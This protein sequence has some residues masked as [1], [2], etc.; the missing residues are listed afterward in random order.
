[1]T[2]DEQIFRQK[3]IAAAVGIAAGALSAIV[4]IVVLVR[5][6]QRILLI[7][8]VTG[9]MT[10]FYLARRYRTLTEQIELEQNES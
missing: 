1:M 4:G 2:Q 7:S 5:D 9:A 6:G 10:A 8:A 3:R